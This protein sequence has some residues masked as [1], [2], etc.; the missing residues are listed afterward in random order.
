MTRKV[1]DAGNDRDLRLIEALLRGDQDSFRELVRRSERWVRGIVYSVLGDLDLLDD[2]V[3]EVWISAWRQ[4]GGLERPGSWRA[5][6]ASLARNAAIDALRRRSSR[7]K[8][9]DRFR[10]REAVRG[11]PEAD[12]PC[13]LEIEDEHRV[14]LDAISRLPARYREV[15]VL[16]HLEDWSY[17]EIAEALS[18]PRE[19]VET[20]LVRARRMLRERL[21]RQ[22]R[23]A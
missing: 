20:R 13:R 5:W 1:L 12:P 9:L 7:R 3:Q 16:R 10:E 23:K 22:A 6:L 4:I 18:L 11:P 14:A 15:F 17:A 21:E 19:T 2:V 8:H